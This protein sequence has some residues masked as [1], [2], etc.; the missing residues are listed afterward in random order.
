MVGRV[1][2]HI[3]KSKNRIVSNFEI[4]VNAFYMPLHPRID[5]LQSASRIKFSR[6]NPE[7]LFIIFLSELKEVFQKYE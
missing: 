2:E 5:I 4:K 6:V 3:F 1:I 7:H